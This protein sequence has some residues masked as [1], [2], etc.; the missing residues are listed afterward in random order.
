MHLALQRLE[1]RF[2]RGWDHV[3]KAQAPGRLTPAAVGVDPVAAPR[4]RLQLGDLLLP[5]ALTAREAADR[6]PGF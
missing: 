2:H 4:E 3:Q 1:V 5:P 6:T